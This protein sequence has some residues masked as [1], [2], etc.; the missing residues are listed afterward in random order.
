MT[1]QAAA[2]SLCPGSPVTPAVPRKKIHFPRPVAAFRSDVF[3]EV[4]SMPM[5]G[6]EQEEVMH[7]KP[8]KPSYLRMF[9]VT[10]TGAFIGV[11]IGIAVELIRPSE[12]KYSGPG[13]FNYTNRYGTP[14]TVKLD[15][16]RTPAYLVLPAVGACVGFLWM[17]YLR[18]SRKE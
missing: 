9:L 10:I 2:R 18:T 4:R 17:L 14:S 5:P 11:V 1:W 16:R 6:E 15:G 12:E 8:K 3:C 13:T 7:R